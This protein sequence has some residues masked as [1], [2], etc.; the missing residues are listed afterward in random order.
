[1][2]WSELYQS[3]SRFCPFHCTNPFLFGTQR[4]WSTI[5]GKQQFLEGQLFPK[6]LMLF[7]MHRG[8]K[9]QKPTK[10]YIRKFVKLSGSYLCLQQFDKFLICSAPNHWKQ[11][12]CKS[13]EIDFGKIRESTSG[14]RWNYFWRVLFIWN[15]CVMS[16]F[17]FLMM[18]LLFFFLTEN[19]VFGENRATIFLL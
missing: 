17:Y 5:Q 12:L 16:L 15:L 18:I 6:L 7:L 19:N 11:K 2:T 8:F 4:T 9:W 10:N 3:C 1:M 13:A 14:F